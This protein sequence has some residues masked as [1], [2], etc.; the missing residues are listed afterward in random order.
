MPATSTP[1]SSYLPLNAGLRARAGKGACPGDGFA[2]GSGHSW[3]HAGGVS[4]QCIGNAQSETREKM[5]PLAGAPPQEFVAALP[6]LPPH[7]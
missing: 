2:R 3:H 7:A 4:S 1:S 5:L 6:G